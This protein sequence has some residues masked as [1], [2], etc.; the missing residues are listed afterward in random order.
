MIGWRQ[1]SNDMLK[2]L[3]DV[4]K[5]VLETTSDSIQRVAH[6]NRSNCWREGVYA[7][8]EFLKSGLK[9]QAEL[10]T[11]AVDQIDAFVDLPEPAGAFTQ[12]L[13]QAIQDL[14]LAEAGMLTNC[15]EILRVVDPVKIADQGRDFCRSPVSRMQAMTREAVDRQMD[16][17]RGW[18]RAREETEEETEEED[19]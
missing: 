13:Q 14:T 1:R 4:Q 9:A 19:E 12:R 17:A 2:T 8:E 10:S 15:S 11:A 18:A 7:M 5:S 6:C 16:L 3:G